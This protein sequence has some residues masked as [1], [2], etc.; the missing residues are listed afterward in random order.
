MPHGPPPP[1]HPLWLMKLVGMKEYE[2]HLKKKN[3]GADP[4]S[5]GNSVAELLLND[6]VNAT[7]N[8]IFG[9][10]DSYHLITCSFSPLPSSENTLMCLRYVD[11]IV[12]SEFVV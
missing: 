8:D 11:R 9:V 5:I 4:V 3:G 2:A 12:K 6:L 10:C 7:A 1:P